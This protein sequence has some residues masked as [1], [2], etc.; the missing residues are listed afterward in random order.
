M[1]YHGSLL[2]DKLWIEFIEWPKITYFFLFFFTFSLTFFICFNSAPSNASEG[3]TIG[4][5]GNA[6][7]QYVMLQNR[8]CETDILLSK[9]ETLR[10]QLRQTMRYVVRQ[11]QLYEY[12]LDHQILIITLL[13]VLPSLWP[14]RT[15]V[16]KLLVTHA[17]IYFVY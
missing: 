11:K 10:R 2:C 1:Y 5:E 17:D 3:I 7:V 12:W 8:L 16:L 15:K 4:L 13:W 14:A 6:C 9:V